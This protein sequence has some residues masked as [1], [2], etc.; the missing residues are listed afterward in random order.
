MIIHHYNKDKEKKN[1]FIK[2]KLKIGIDFD[3]TLV[4]MKEP[5]I[6]VA[7]RNLNI[8]NYEKPK[9]Y[10]YSN[11]EENLRNEVFRLFDDPVH[12]CNIIK[13][14]RVHNK[15]L[16]WKSFG[17]NLV[18]ITGGNE[19]IRK[20]RTQWINN[21]F[22]MLEKINFVDI[23]KSKK[24]IFEEENIDVW[25]DDSPIDTVT[26]HEMGILTCLISNT[27]TTYNWG[28]RQECP[29]SVYVSVADINFC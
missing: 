22:P 10:F 9:D 16:L 21:N 18:L 27:D 28:L 14:P 26:A 23:G 13:L 4:K 5:T 3:N 24:D 2:Q 7:A 8:K 20:A 1:K 25:I 19:P 11:V 29:F 6:K 17:H 15:L 12:A